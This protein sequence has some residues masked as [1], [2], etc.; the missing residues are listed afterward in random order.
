[1]NSPKRKNRYIQKDPTGIDNLMSDF[2][3]RHGF[4]RQVTSAMIVQKAR[5]LIVDLLPTHAKGDVRVISFNDSV[6]KVAVRHAAAGFEVGLIAER[7]R[8]ILLREFPSTDIAKITH[9]LDPKVF[10]NFVQ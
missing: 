3:K 5:E 7:L 1:M 6:L 8:D 10:E 4:E 9:K 2:L